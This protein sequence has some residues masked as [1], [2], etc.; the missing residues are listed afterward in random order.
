[1][2]TH[3]QYR[4]KNS[5]GLPAAEGGS[6]GEIKDLER[7]LKMEIMGECGEV[8][9]EMVVLEEKATVGEL[10]KRDERRDSCRP[11]RDQSHPKR[12]CSPP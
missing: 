12:R 6:R 10:K 11:P 3:A 2:F 7:E 5:G 4:L 8:R 1:M 9:K